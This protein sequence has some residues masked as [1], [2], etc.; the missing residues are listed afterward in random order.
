MRFSSVF[1]G[2]NALF[3]LCFYD[4]TC[5]GKALLLF[6]FA[7]FPLLGTLQQALGQNTANIGLASESYFII[8]FPFLI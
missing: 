5:S 8:E 7:L 2:G 4:K 1:F 3:L 6:V